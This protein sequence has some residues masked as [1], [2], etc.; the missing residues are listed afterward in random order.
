MLVGCKFSKTDIAKYYWKYK[1]GE[2]LGDVLVFNNDN[3]M[4]DDN[5]NVFKEKNRIGTIIKCTDKE[6]VVLTSNNKKGYYAPLSFSSEYKDN[7][8]IQE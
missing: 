7:T 4:L 1:E 2:Y 8:D 5:Y 6:L 3:L